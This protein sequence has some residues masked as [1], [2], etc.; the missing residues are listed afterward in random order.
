MAL[1]LWRIRSQSGGHSFTLLVKKTTAFLSL[2]VLPLLSITKTNFADGN[3]HDTVHLPRLCLHLVSSL[4]LSQTKGALMWEKRSA[5]G[6][7]A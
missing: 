3:H 1:I 6:Q 4:Q 7:T 5:E 2:A